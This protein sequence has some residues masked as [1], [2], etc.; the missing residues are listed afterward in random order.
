MAVIDQGA[1]GIRIAKVH[2]QSHAGIL[3]GPAVVVGHIYGIAQEG[4]IDGPA[5]K[6]HQQKMQLMD[7][8]GVQFAGSILDDP[9]F[10]IA[11]FDDDIR[12]G[13]SRD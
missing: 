5:V 12:L 2:A 9:I 13:G 11:V 6:G 7:V 10:H 1:H 4:F 8:K 3:Q